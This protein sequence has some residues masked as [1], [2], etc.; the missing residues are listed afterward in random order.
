M[1]LGMTGNSDDTPTSFIPPHDPAPSSSAPEVPPAEPAPAAF[2]PSDLKCPRCSY[3]LRG[4]PTT[5]ACP[6][7][8]A[9]LAG[10][11][12]PYPPVVIPQGVVE[13]DQTCSRC[14][15]NLR[16]LP[17]D[18]R[19]PECGTPVAD[20]LRGILLG[21]A[22][23]EYLA[24]IHSGLRIVL[25]AIL[26]MVVLTVL[27]VAGAFIFRGSRE[28]HVILE[29]LVFLN[30]LA[31]IIG[32]WRYTEPD[33]G[34]VGRES[35]RAAR[36]VVRVAVAIQA[37]A[38]AVSPILLLMGAPT[39]L[40]MPPPGASTALT[41][42]IVLAGIASLVSTCAFA[43]Q[44][45][46]VMRYTRWMGERVPDFYIITRTR[47]YMWLLPVLYVVGSCVA[48]GPLIALVMYWNLLERLA[49]HLKAIR[50]TGRPA[51]LKKMLPGG[52]TPIRPV[53]IADQGADPRAAP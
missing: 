12:S 47:T 17:T 13:A 30:A 10:S 49:K 29:G 36:K 2:V 6:E 27:M 44:F 51:Y 11:P 14:S 9:P 39:S 32:Y 40:G 25:T 18:G 50:A 16:G 48:I 8:G 21:Y 26:V 52:G 7:C 23:P 38:S 22:S 45:F 43:V 15:Y 4:L 3:N 24:T 35:P 41:T 31:A 1:L 34:Y 19:C 42:L 37:V 53:V 5:S 20:S 28:V 46:A 33:L